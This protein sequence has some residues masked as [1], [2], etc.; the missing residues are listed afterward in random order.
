MQLT[1]A[2]NMLK[3]IWS[4]W[5]CSRAGRFALEWEMGSHSFWKWNSPGTGICLGI[6]CSLLQVIAVMYQT[7]QFTIYKWLWCSIW[8]F[9]TKEGE[10]DKS[11][12][13]KTYF[14][15]IKAI[16]SDACHLLWSKWHQSSRRA[17]YFHQIH[18]LLEH[19]RRKNW[20]CCCPQAQKLKFK[21]L[22]WP[23]FLD[24]IPLALNKNHMP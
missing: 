12:S 7:C 16:Q 10:S 3:T 5:G 24:G 15:D 8:E 20:Y 6:L 19:F 23:I 9:M 13:D 21:K 2:Q 4:C 22:T 17:K 1:I 18:D 11:D 14:L